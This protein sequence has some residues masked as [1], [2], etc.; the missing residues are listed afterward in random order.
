MQSYSRSRQLTTC[1]ANIAGNH[2]TNINKI[3]DTSFDI[4][5]YNLQDKFRIH[6]YE[7]MEVLFE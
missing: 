3:V 5:F 6:I 7:F 2:Y 1:N 4:T